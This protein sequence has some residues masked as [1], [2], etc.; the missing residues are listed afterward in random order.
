MK[1]QYIY[2]YTYIHIYI[3]IYI[4]IHIYIYNN[5][6]EGL[7]STLIP[8]FPTKNQPGNLKSM[9]QQAKHRYKL[10]KAAREGKAR[11]SLTLAKSSV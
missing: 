4:Y 7:Y 9:F 5:P 10:G 8:S 6:F 11:L 1:A 3:Y 2:I